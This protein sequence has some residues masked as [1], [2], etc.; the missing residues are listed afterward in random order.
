M[1]IDYILVTMNKIALL[2]IFSFLSGC[3]T[4]TSIEELEITKEH[5]FSYSYKIINETDSQYGA[6]DVSF[7]RYNNKSGDR[8]VIFESA[9]EV[10]PFL[11]DFPHH[12][13]AIFAFPK[14]GGDA[15]ILT[16][17]Y[18]DADGGSGLLFMYDPITNE[19]KPMQSN[20]EYARTKYDKHTFLS[21]KQTRVA[22]VFNDPSENPGMIIP[23]EQGNAQKL[24]LVDLLNDTVVTIVDLPKG[25]TL[26][27]QESMLGSH[28][29]IQWKSENTIRY[30]VYDQTMKSRSGS[31]GH[32]EA[33]LIEYREVSL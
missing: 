18:T 31:Y 1:Q 5:S 3:S 30:A 13:L 26:N 17:T 29:D 14:G 24:Q 2:L 33:P 4:E 8:E 19:I 12:T 21:P 27:S 32:I 23:S 20:Q 22:F 11:R 10:F 28:F 25:E 15:V 16:D 6:Y 9:K 7:V